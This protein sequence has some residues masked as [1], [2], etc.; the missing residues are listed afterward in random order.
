LS[1]ATFGSRENTVEFL[2]R[3]TPKLVT[4]FHLF[5]GQLKIKKSIR[6]IE[7]NVWKII[8]YMYREIEFDQ[9][10]GTDIR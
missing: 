6:L 7:V 1:N 9:P 4:L 5:L 8:S 3:T 10:H 2:Y